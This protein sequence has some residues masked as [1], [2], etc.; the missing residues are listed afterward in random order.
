MSEFP[1]KDPMAFFELEAGY[2]AKDLKRAYT[3]KI[4]KYK[5]EKFPEEFKQI[6]EAYEDLERESSYSRTT[7]EKPL[8]SIK[9][10]LSSETGENSDENVVNISQPSQNI[11][12]EGDSIVVNIPQDTSFSDAYKDLDGTNYKDTYQKLLKKEDRSCREEI[13]LM[14]LE[15][16]VKDLKALL[17]RLPE[18]LKK[19]SKDDLADQFVCYL[20][21]E[22]IPLEYIHDFLVN[23]APIL[24]GFY[25]NTESQFQKI[26][27][28]KDFQEFEKTLL[29]CEKEVSFQEQSDSTIFYSRIIGKY[30][31]RVPPEWRDEKIKFINE[32]S[33]L[34]NDYLDERLN[35]ID[36]LCEFVDSATHYKEE[37]KELLQELR[38]C[39]QI[40]CEFQGLE[41]EVFF[42]NL[43]K[44]WR[45]PDYLANKMTHEAPYLAPA[46]RIITIISD[47]Y[48]DARTI[49]K[50]DDDNSIF[51]FKFLQR[52]QKGKYQ[53]LPQIMSMISF[54][55]AVTKV[56][57]YILIGTAI[58]LILFSVL[59]MF[60]NENVS[61][62]AAGLTTII[63]LPIAAFTTLFPYRKLWP[64][65]ENWFDKISL[66]I[67]HRQY[68]KHLRKPTIN[69]IIENMLTEGEINHA[70]HTYQNS[71]IQCSYMQVGVIEDYAL[72]FAAIASEHRA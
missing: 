58:Y 12:V 3:R 30:F 65:I 35:F 66:K 33:S 6:R 43:M 20:L 11:T 27:R 55:Q 60:I 38:E 16:Q 14:L 54:L 59:F 15:E 40:Y 8:A 1:I 10:D 39:I 37:E 57:L 45:E 51:I 46:F 26:L 49:K 42:Y 71:N 36:M 19:F 63:F 7:Q 23:L 53:N 24:S 29:A 22:D 2:S 52:F 56:L 67:T 34:E 48:K 50:H 13:L 17:D 21:R 41:G 28:E 31:F 70:I 69:L 4:K 9:L 5:P 64:Y 32:N 68:R 44:K 72:S 18:F 61:P 47:T 62:D 25:Y